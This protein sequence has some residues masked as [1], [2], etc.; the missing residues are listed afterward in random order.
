M[1]IIQKNG[2]CM[3][4]IIIIG[5]GV[6]GLS[7]GIYARLSGHTA[8]I[9]EKHTEAGGNLTGWQ[10][11]PYHIDNCIHWLTGTN[12]ATKTYKMWK[13]LGVLDNGIY[14][15]PSLYTCELDG[16][17]LSLCRGADRLENELISV[18]PAD[19][20]EIR[21]FASAVRAAAYLSGLCGGKKTDITKLFRYFKMTAGELA[22]KFSHPLI[23]MFLSSF[24]TEDF[25][26]LGLIFVFASFCYGNADLPRGGSKEAARNMVRR[27]L[28]LHGELHTGVAAEKLLLDK[29]TARSVLL[30]DGTEVKGDYFI[31]T[32]DPE[33][34]YVRLTG[35]SLPRAL[36]KMKN[37]GKLS[38]FSSVHCAFSCP[39][40]LD[41][42]GDLV[43]EMT[44]DA[45]I[46]SGAKYLTLR[47]FSHE[48]SYAPEG[49]TVLQAFFF[50]R[51]D[52][53]R[54]IIDL[55]R[56]K[57]A[58]EKIKKITAE[59]VSGQIELRYPGL[60]G[61]LRLLDVWT[62]ATYRKF[63]GSDCGT[64]MS[65][66]FSSGYVPKTCRNRADGIKN[67]YLAT[68]WLQPP[69][70]LPTAANAGKNAVACIN[71]AENRVS[72]S[73]RAP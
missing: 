29:N 11:G 43:F 66:A 20:S 24:L 51:E 30:D 16:R 1:S 44:E 27:F 9:Y 18:S 4:K 64:Y 33:S 12:S 7:A 60:K 52:R 55:D 28:S 57:K 25:G 71:R 49:E 61:K 56:N 63:T 69:G 38:R 10:R 14:S 19:I 31:L 45:K 37:N 2:V 8:V 6:A 36:Y 22:E 65:Y 48:S 73:K 53:C 13:T 3:A 42:D 21:S 58:Y 70:G 54:Q 5:G 39:K 26:S 40:N 17:R 23:K 72:R 68:Q 41:F 50:C 34:S 46:L 35:K 59:C 15:P 47:N 32:A 62:P 67:V